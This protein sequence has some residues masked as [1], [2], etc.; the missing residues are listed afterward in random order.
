VIVDGRQPNNV[1]ASRSSRPQRVG[2]EP[3][4]PHFDRPTRTPCL[5]PDLWTA[6]RSARSAPTAGR[7]YLTAYDTC[8]TGGY[9]RFASNTV[10]RVPQHVYAV[11]LRRLRNLHRASRTALAVLG[12]RPWFERHALGL[13]ARTRAGIWSCKNSTFRNNPFGVCPNSLNNDDNRRP[14]TARVTAPR[15]N[16]KITPG[17]STNLP[18]STREHLGVHDLPHNLVENR[19]NLRSRKNGR[20]AA[21]TG[22]GVGILLPGDLRRSSCSKTR[23]RTRQLLDPLPRV[24][25][26]RS[27]RCDTCT[28]GRLGTRRTG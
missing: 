2:R 3:H 28:S 4:V 27:A 12:R 24:Y 14:R 8:L 26:T 15:R 18:R 22:Q 10:T 6:G 17:I 23:F 20:A 11:R 19:N 9:G 13:S 16:P 21:P 7:P 25:R 5:Q 1:N